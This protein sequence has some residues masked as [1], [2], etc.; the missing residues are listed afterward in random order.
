MVSAG[1]TE[2]TI[3]RKPGILVKSSLAFQANCREILLIW[4]KNG[5]DGLRLRISSAPGGTQTAM[6]QFAD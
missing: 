1:H 2:Q 4:A 5:C 3:N 6:A